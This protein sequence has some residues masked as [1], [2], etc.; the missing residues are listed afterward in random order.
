MRRTAVLCL[1]TVAACAPTVQDVRDQPVRFEMQVSANMIDVGSC[2]ATL[3]AT[4]EELDV[5]YYP[6]KAAKRTEVVGSMPSVLLSPKQALVVFEL[7]EEPTGGTRV[8]FKRRPLAFA[9]DIVERKARERV[10]RCGRA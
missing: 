1:L 5:S 2:L 7:S 9:G 6:L 3:Y 8:V 4:V 10:E